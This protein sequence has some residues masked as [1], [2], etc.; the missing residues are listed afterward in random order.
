MT[1]PIGKEGGTV[2]VL[3]SAYQ[4]T[5]GNFQP[6]IVIGGHVT[7][8]R[9][10]A[11]VTIPGDLPFGPF[12]LS[13]NKIDGH[14]PPLW[15]MNYDANAIEIVNNDEVPIYQIIYKRPDVIEIYGIFLAGNKI[16]AV[17]RR[18]TEG[19]PAFVSGRPTRVDPAAL[20]LKRIFK[21]PSSAYLEQRVLRNE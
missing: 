17:T 2:N 6:I 15:D 14:L 13:G 21:Y 7:K 19:M 12:K 5:N 3:A 20:G 1:N 11:N 9:F 16:M 8:N 10:F 18:G 4:D